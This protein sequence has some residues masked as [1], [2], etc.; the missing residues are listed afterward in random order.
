MDIRFNESIT[1]F[2]RHVAQSERTFYSTVKNSFYARFYRHRDY[3]FPVFVRGL[4]SQLGLYFT[5]SI[6]RICPHL[7]VDFSQ[8]FTAHT[9]VYYLFGLPPLELAIELFKKWTLAFW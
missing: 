3:L 9:P 7:A 5:R 2:R 8:D 1:A 4:V 6:C